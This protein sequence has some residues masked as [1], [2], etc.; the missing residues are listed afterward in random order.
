MAEHM[1]AMQDRVKEAPMTLRDYFVFRRSVRLEQSPKTKGSGT[2][3]PTGRRR[4]EGSD[5][6]IEVAIV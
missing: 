5:T 3:D 2:A 1:D 6:E 4:S